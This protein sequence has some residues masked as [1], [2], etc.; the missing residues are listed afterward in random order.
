MNA[1]LSRFE[2]ILFLIVPVFILRRLLPKLRRFSFFKETVDS[3]TPISFSVWYNQK[4][5]G[6]CKSAYWPVHP[7]S[8]VINPYNIYCGVE[9]CPG[10]SPG[11]YIQA[12]GKIYIGNYT[13]IAPNV[14][15]IAANHNLYDNREHILSSV[16]IGEYCWI[17][18][19]AVI[20][21]G[22]ELGDFT[23]VGAGAVVTKSFAEGFCVIGGNPARV[24]KK[25][26]KS[27]CVRYQSKVEYNGYIPS[28]DF[29]SYRKKHLTV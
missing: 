14:G 16:R 19:G 5:V 2:R 7:T 4:V 21:P 8:V 13:S 1:D 25:I 27:L 9:T 3:S 28:K 12:I 10:Y 18:M 23:V 20:L 15:I 24:I 22:V 11:N 17:G 26:D 6:H 29:E